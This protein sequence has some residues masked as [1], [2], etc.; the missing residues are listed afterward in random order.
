MN[1]TNQL[2][3][4]IEDALYFAEQ[5]HHDYC[6]PE[7][8]LHV[9]IQQPAVS[10]LLEKSGADLEKIKAELKTF[11]TEQMIATEEAWCRKLSF[12]MGALL[13]GAEFN[14]AASGRT[15]VG[16]DDVLVQ[17]MDLS[18][19]WCAY[20]LQNSGVKKIRLMETITT[21]RR[22]STLEKEADLSDDELLKGLDDFDF[23][24]DLIP[25]DMLSED[26]SIPAL[27][28][29]AVNLTQKAKDGE[30]DPLIG[31]EEELDRTMQVLCRRKKN[32]PLHVGDPG[33]GKTAITEG[34]AQKIVEGSVPELLKDSEIF[35]LN[36]GALIAGTQYRGDF[37][38]RLKRVTDELLE[39]KNAILFIDEIHT[40]IGAGTGTSGTLDA[41]NI[42][43]PVLTSGKVRCIGSTTFEEYTKYFEKDRA[44]SRRFQKIDILEPGRED[45]LKILTRL[46]KHYEEF[47]KA[48][49]T[50]EAIESAIDLSIQHLA[51]RKLPDKA[52]D[53]I[54]EAGAWCRLHA[55]NKDEEITIDVPVI[56][57]ITSRMAGIPLEEVTQS[58]VE[59]LKGLEENLKKKIFGQDKAV[60]AVSLAVKKSRAGFRN[61]EKPEAVFLFVGPTGVG[62]TELTKILAQTLGEKLLRY[63]MSEYQ[64]AYTVSRLIG[65][66]PGYVGYE[67][68]GVLTEEVRKA[69]HAVILFDEIEKAHPSIFNL[70]LQVMDYGTLTDSQG[71]KADFRNSIIIMTSNAGA[72]ELSAGKIGFS[73]KTENFNEAS[74]TLKEAVNRTFT[75]EFRNR[76]DAVITFGNLPRNIVLDIAKKEVSL[77]K[78]RL[79][80]KKVI[81]EAEDAVIEK[82]ADEGYS[83]EFGARNISRTVEEKIFLP[84][85]DEVL[86][87]K[88]SAGGKVKAVLKEGKI[89]FIF[90]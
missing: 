52:I 90:N 45:T 33:V 23:M 7:H 8:L 46:K 41:A 16:I 35:A 21:I 83:P 66:A 28:K 59:K 47:H 67:N 70:L 32:N 65:S 85:V 79:L 30:L 1:R 73:G 57:K 76:L 63:D 55:E 88:L 44:L 6:T 53:I 61:I 20:I 31:R 87:G 14:A 69:H 24:S 50:D 19:S 64:E 84:L 78:E 81:L 82:I 29:Y 17:M 89:E 4:L 74:A 3:S 72:S 22:N 12:Q 75:P 77:V 5:S 39:K 43:K 68:G 40:I 10:M 56:R 36:M 86:F 34:L 62:K 49:Y 71:R 25:D 26:T 60:K 15:S 48:R 27:E 54:D 42:L 13:A 38:A 51:E 80:A 11:F 2:T 9:S 58:E 18:D 37:E